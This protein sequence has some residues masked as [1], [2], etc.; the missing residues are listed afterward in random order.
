MWE[1]LAKVLQS[2]LQDARNLAE[3]VPEYLSVHKALGTSE[4]RFF[5]FFFQ[6]MEFR[7]RRNSHHSCVGYSA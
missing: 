7:L 6:M 1:W 4:P 3:E 5:Y 2:K